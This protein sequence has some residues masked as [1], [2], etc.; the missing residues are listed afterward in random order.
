MGAKHVTP[1]EI[2][3]MLNLYNQL[4]TYAAVGQKMGRSGST[5]AKYVKMKGVPLNV[6]IAVQNL[7]KK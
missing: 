3:E 4:G 5:V 2:V 7:L 1:E 6:Q